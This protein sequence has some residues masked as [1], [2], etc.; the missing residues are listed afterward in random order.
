MKSPGSRRP[1]G[2]GSPRRVAGEDGI[3]AVGQNGSSTSPSTEGFVWGSADGIVWSRLPAPVTPRGLNTGLES[4][5]SFDGAF[6]STGWEPGGA[7][8][9][10]TD[11]SSWQKAVVP[12]AT[13]GDIH[14]IWQGRG[15]LYAYGFSDFTTPALWTSA[16]GRTWTD[17]AVAQPPGGDPVGGVLEV[18]GQLVLVRVDPGTGS[19]SLWA[20]PDG[21]G[22][23]RLPDDPAF[24]DFRVGARPTTFGD[25]LVIAGDRIVNGIWSPVVLV[26]ADLRSW[27]LIAF[28]AVSAAEA[29]GEEGK[30]RASR[31]SA[32]ACS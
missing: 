14:G 3:V 17:T 20:S 5:I 7:I 32:P 1:T 29:G 21:Q 16:D 28:D 6:I 13:G 31:S 15:Q 24:T 12:R 22:W 10:S 2:V 26:T 18:A 9:W 4:V 27:D 23:S 8:W 25:R 11:L 30:W 19:L